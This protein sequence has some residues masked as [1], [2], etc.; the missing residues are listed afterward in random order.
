MDITKQAALDAV[1]V[2]KAIVETAEDSGF[3]H[4]SYKGR[5]RCTCPRKIRKTANGTLVWDHSCPQIPSKHPFFEENFDAKKKA[6]WGEERH[7]ADDMFRAAT[8]FYEK[9]FG[10]LA[11]E[12]TSY[13][14]W[15]FDD[16][17]AKRADKA[18]QEACDWAYWSATF[19]LDFEDYQQEQTRYKSN[20]ETLT[21]VK[22]C[23]VA[24]GVGTALCFVVWMLSYLISK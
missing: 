18:L 22:F 16:D 8:S 23:G 9:H 21:V 3:Y 5:T 7:H 19:G 4:G 10:S 13:K 15:H 1:I 6:R 17:T 2:A 20:Q 24:L 11:G 14:N 12:D